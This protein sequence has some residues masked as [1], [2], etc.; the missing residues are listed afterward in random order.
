[1]CPLTLTLLWTCS[2]S[3]F[4]EMKLEK[5]SFSMQLLCLVWCLVIR[6]NPFGD[7]PHCF[8]W[9]GA[10][11]SRRA[12]RISSRTSQTPT[13][14]FTPHTD[15]AWAVGSNSIYMGP[16]VSVGRLTLMSLKLTSDDLL[17]LSF[18]I[19]FT[20]D[21]INGVSFSANVAV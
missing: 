14:A 5:M 6:F 7:S 1:M 12:A 2:T 3:G 20:R 21:A 11:R 10:L 18:L 19:V 13:F 4:G 8:A 16:Y 9:D 17:S 15:E